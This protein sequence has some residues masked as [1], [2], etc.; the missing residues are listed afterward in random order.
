MKSSIITALFAVLC[1]AGSPVAAN[2]A[3][4]DSIAKGKTVAFD[5][6]KGN[7]LA[8]HVMDDGALAGTVG[9][10]LVQMKMRFPDRSLLREQIWDAGKR[11]PTS[12]M[13]PFGRH[14]I[15]TEEEIDWVVD[16]LYSL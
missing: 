12:M 3:Q 4:S 9:P 6:S 2:E 14:E 8:C 16:Y 7:C 11:N 10:P 15:L 1:F 13:P 5:R